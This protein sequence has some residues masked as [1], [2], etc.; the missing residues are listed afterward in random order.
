MEVDPAKKGSGDTDTSTDS[1]SS[2]TTTSVEGFA[3]A[4]FASLVQNGE[5]P[6][7]TNSFQHMLSVLAGGSADLVLD[8]ACGD[9]NRDEA[10]T[11]ETTATWTSSEGR[12]SM[13]LAAD[14]VYIDGE[15]KSDYQRSSS[16]QVV[17]G[18]G[19]VAYTPA[20][21]VVISGKNRGQAR[22]L[23]MQL[24]Q[25]KGPFRLDVES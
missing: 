16:Y 23:M 1:L 20:G 5:E 8:L 13:C 4:L 17:N 12:A 7:Y 10:G 18:K 2:T 21:E 25:S 22:K 15:K 24:V 14:A 9:A 11:Y 3:L 19:Q 6:S